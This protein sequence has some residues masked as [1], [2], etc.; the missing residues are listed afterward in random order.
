MNTILTTDNTLFANLI[1]TKSRDAFS[2][3]YDK[4]ASALFGVI[5][6]IVQNKVA[7]EELLQQVFVKIW[8]NIDKYETSKGTLF[9][10]MLHITHDICIAYL[11]N[12]QHEMLTQ[13]QFPET[14]AIHE[15]AQYKTQN[16]ELNDCTLNP[17]H[18][19]KQVIELLFFWGYSQE[20]IAQQLQIPL[21]TVQTRSRMGLQ[22][23][24]AL[25][26]NFNKTNFELANG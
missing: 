6:R 2:E 26:E 25:Y 21:N 18:K 23:L 13:L 9:T 1:K 17:E 22:Q 11:R 3:L 4:Y 14:L 10:W 16:E 8:N 12:A 5:C 24:R 7:A 19:Y 15:T 20:E